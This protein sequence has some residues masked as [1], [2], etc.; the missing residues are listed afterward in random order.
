LP[1][2]RAAA[3][4]KQAELLRAL[5]AVIHADRRVSLHEFVVLTLVRAQL[6]PRPKA[7]NDRKSISQMRSQVVL[8]LSLLAHGARG[9]GATAEV[10]VDTAFRAGVKQL[11]M[12][13]A[14]L[15]ARSALSL[16]RCG[17]ALT[18]L[19]SLAPL[20]KAELMGAF[21]AAVTADKKVRLSEAELMRMVGATLGCPVPPLFDS[22]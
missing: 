20:A 4:E 17:N 21:F 18:E 6:S 11:G 16:E 22:L 3:P 2:V 9:A 12:P 14:G 1:T 10:E 8:I 15:V 19:N 7:G 5:E 13:E